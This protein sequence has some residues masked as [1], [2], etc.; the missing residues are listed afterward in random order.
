MNLKRNESD[1]I[2]EEILLNGGGY[3][4]GVGMSQN[5]A[6]NMAYAGKT[7]ADILNFFYQ[8]TVVEE[9]YE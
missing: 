6:K 9:I 4:H 1:G 2:L 3:G 5:G 7:Y 8:D